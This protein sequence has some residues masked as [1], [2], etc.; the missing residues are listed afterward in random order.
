MGPSGRARRPRGRC[1]GSPGAGS[2]GGSGPSAGE[3]EGHGAGTA[4]ERSSD[5]RIDGG[6]GGRRRGA[7]HER[8]IADAR[9]GGRPGGALWS[10]PGALI[11]RRGAPVPGGR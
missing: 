8:G 9:A 4:R 10:A 11:G 1:S 3:G 2:V 6:A 7:G 5:L